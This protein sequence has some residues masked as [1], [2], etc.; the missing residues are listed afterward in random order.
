[1]Y[2]RYDYLLFVYFLILPSL[3]YSSI[4][5]NC[6]FILV[7]IVYAQALEDLHISTIIVN[8][9]MFVNVKLSID[10]I[11]PIGGFAYTYIVNI[12]VSIEFIAHYN[13][14]YIDAWNVC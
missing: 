6:F 14:I 12:F 13:Y 3:L 5:F 8:I 1:M 4:L 10:R 9:S 7:L 2:S 11:K